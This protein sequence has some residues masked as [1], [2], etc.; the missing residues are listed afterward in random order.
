VKIVM[1]K[2]LDAKSGDSYHSDLP[3]ASKELRL[4]STVSVGIVIEN[5]DKSV[6][7]LALT[8]SECGWYKDTC[9]IP[10]CLIKETKVLYHDRL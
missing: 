1:V 3:D 10:K 9:N 8:R 2:W 6:L 5:P 7:S 4:E